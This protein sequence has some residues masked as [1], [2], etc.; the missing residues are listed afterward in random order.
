MERLHN[1]SAALVT[2]KVRSPG[3]CSSFLLSSG[4]INKKTSKAAAATAASNRPCESMGGGR[5]QLE[6]SFQLHNLPAC[7]KNQVSPG[8]HCRSCEVPQIKPRYYCNDA[9]LLGTSALRERIPGPPILQI[10]YGTGNSVRI[11]PF[12]TMP[13]CKHSMNAT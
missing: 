4:E 8:S 6:I 12:H 9:I 1:G 2:Y 13:R 7:S 11:L 10:R 5:S 3:L